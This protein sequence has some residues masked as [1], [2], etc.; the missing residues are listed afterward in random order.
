MTRLPRLGPKHTTPRVAASANAQRQRGQLPEA[1]IGRR[2]AA[3]GPVAAITPSSS[4]SAVSSASRSV[5]TPSIAATTA[6]VC[7]AVRRSLGEEADGTAAR[8]PHHRA[9]SRAGS[10][11]TVPRGPR[12]LTRLRSLHSA[13]RTPIRVTPSRRS[14]MESSAAGIT[15]AC[16]PHMAPTTSASGSPRAG[17][18]SQWRCRRLAQT[19]AQVRR[20]RVAPVAPLTERPP[21]RRLRPPSSSWPALPRH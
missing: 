8:A 5:S 11:C 16:A 20:A 3:Q 7:A 9:R 1:K 14:P 15:W 18:A 4:S 19:W 17:V 12:V 6:S 21:R 2:S 13:S 10:R